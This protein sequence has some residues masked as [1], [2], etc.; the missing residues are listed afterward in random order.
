M[1]AIFFQTIYEL[2]KENPKL[3][4]I[5]ADTAYIPDF[6]QAFP[7]QYLD[8]GIAEQNMIGVAAG[9]ALEGKIP[10]TYSIVNFATMRCLEQVRTQ[11]AFNNLN[12]KIVSCGTGFDYGPLG[13]TH[14]ATEDLSIM[15]VIPNLTIFSPCDPIETVAVTKAAFAIDGPCFIRI[16]HGGEPNLHSSLIKNFQVGKVYTLKEGEDIKIF[17]TG[18][19]AGE[20]MAAAV[21]LG[22]KGHDVGVYSFPTI[23][24]IDRDFI[25]ECVHQAKIILSVEEHSIIGGFGGA[26]AEVIAEASEKSAVFRRIGINDIFTDTIGDK[27]YLKS[28]YSLD[29]ESIKEIVESMNREIARNLQ[30]PSTSNM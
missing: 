27:E 4:F 20:V 11:V 9:M 10:F 25:F 8:V 15:R 28:V 23:K 5:K 1:K 2:A 24:P 30:I 19:I 26:V 16:G 29:K 17:V 18:S 22:E 6:Q 14:H 7:N 3:Q 21:E 12:V 13:A